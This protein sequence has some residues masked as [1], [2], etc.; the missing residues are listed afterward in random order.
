[1]KRTS[2]GLYALC[3]GAA[4]TL[5][6]L[7]AAAGNPDKQWNRGCADAKAG[8][9]DRSKH[10]DAY[11]KGW[12]ACKNEGSSS[13]SGQPTRDMQEADDYSRGCDDAKAGSYDRANP[14]PAYERG[15][16]SC[17]QDSNSESADAGANRQKEWD[18]G[19]ADSKANSY[20][21]ARHNADYEAG[22]QACKSN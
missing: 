3:L 15:W 2:G 7:P 6:A 21:R 4:L 10:S 1:M 9:Y 5:A 18:R 12:K 22:W 13:S 17:K 20:D 16:Q 11:E 19:C 8:T 14:T